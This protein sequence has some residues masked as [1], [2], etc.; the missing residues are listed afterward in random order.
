MSKTSHGVVAS[1]TTAKLDRQ[2][3]GE[4]RHLSGGDGV[5]DIAAIH[6]A[7]AGVTSSRPDSRRR[8]WPSRGRN[9]R[10]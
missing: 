4:L 3:V 1:S 2:A 6:G 9:M 5:A 7:A 10:R 8:S